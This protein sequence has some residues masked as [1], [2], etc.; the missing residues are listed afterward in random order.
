MINQNTLRQIES[1]LKK[2]KTIQLS[3]AKN[4][5]QLKIGVINYHKINL[6][7]AK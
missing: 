5:K 2:G 3:Y 1:E 4:S 7:N 6:E